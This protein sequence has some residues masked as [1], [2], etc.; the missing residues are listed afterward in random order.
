MA[1]IDEPTSDNLLRR[2]RVG[3]PGN[4]NAW[5]H[6]ERSAVA[7]IRRRLS[8]ARIKALA[9]VMHRHGMLPADN[10]L[11][12]FRV[13]PVRRDQLDLLRRLDPELAAVLVQG[14]FAG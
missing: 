1:R 14:G 3:Q 12:R 11:F 9:H 10:E 8:T 5:R 13:R 2:D 7:T 4:K 6:G